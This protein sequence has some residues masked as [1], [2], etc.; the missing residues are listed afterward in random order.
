MAQKKKGK[1]NKK[2]KKGGLSV[3]LVIFIIIPLLFIGVLDGLV[4]TITGI[5]TTVANIVLEVLDI[6][7][8][9][10]RQI[11]LTW[12]TYQW[13]GA[14][15]DNFCSRLFGSSHFN[16][17]EYIFQ[18]QSPEI[19]ITEEQ[20]NQEM[21]K[22]ESVIDLEDAGLTR[23][24]VADMLLAYLSNMYPENYTIKIKLGGLT[25]PKKANGKISLLKVIENEDGTQEFVD[26]ACYSEEG[27]T[28]IYQN[29]YLANLNEDGSESEYSKAV[30]KFLGQCY[31]IG[32]TAGTIKVYNFK[33]EEF[34]EHLQ[35]GDQI[36]D[37]NYIHTINSNATLQPLDYSTD[38]N[39]YATPVEL[40]TSLMLISGSDGFLDAFID[41]V[42]D[43]NK[44]KVGIY[45]TSIES[46]ETVIE[47][48]NQTTVVS[49]T[50]TAQNGYHVR[51]VTDEG[52]VEDENITCEV[53]LGAEAEDI[54]YIEN[55]P[56]KIGL[57]ITNN[58]D[59]RVT[60]NLYLNGRI[61]YDPDAIMPNEP[62]QISIRA[63][64]Y[65]FIWVDPPTTGATREITKQE[66]QIV[67]KTKTINIVEEKFDT[68]IISVESWHTIIET[69][70]TIKKTNTY[71]SKNENAEIVEMLSD[72]Y[73]INVVTQ[74]QNNTYTKAQTPE[75]FAIAEI[76]NDNT[77]I[78][79][80]SS[81]SNRDN[82]LLNCIFNRV[83]RTGDENYQEYEFEQMDVSYG[84]NNTKTLISNTTSTLETTVKNEIDNTDVFLGL[85]SNET[86]EYTLGVQ[87]KSK[88]AGGK[89]VKYKD[90]YNEQA[91]VGE[92]L[93]NG[94]DLLFELLDSYSS[95]EGITQVMKYIMWRYSGIDYGVTTFEFDI[96]DDI[97]FSSV[98]QV[99]LGD[100][101]E[102]RI[103]YSLRFSGFN[104]EAISAI[105]AT[106]DYVSNGN[107]NVNRNQNEAIGIMAWSGVRKEKLIE[108][109]NSQGKPWQDE[110]IQIQYLIAEL[111]Q[112]PTGEVKDY[113]T[114]QII[115]RN[116]YDYNSLCNATTV[117]DATKA[118]L[119]TFNTEGI[120]QNTE[121]PQAQI[122]ES[123]K[124]Y[125]E[126][127]EGK[128]MQGG[129]FRYE[130]VQLRGE[131]TPPPVKRKGTFTSS[132]TGRTFTVYYQGAKSDKYFPG[133]CNRAS[134][135]SI[136][137]GYKKANQTEADVACDAL[138]AGSNLLS[139]PNSTRNFLSKYNLEMRINKYSYSQENIRTLLM[140]GQYIAVW[141]KAYGTPVYGASGHKYT[142]LYH[143]VAILG[144]RNNNGTEE[145][146]ISNSTGG[147]KGCGWKNINEFEV[148]KNNIVY[149]NNIY[150]KQ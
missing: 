75:I 22:L 99:V 126:E 86:G 91:E 83:I 65:Q 132:I 25:I 29:E 42:N 4:S 97:N 136:A 72:S 32:D 67:K 78:S 18:M 50:S 93:E 77:I 137:S 26:M 114:F 116:G 40:M 109:A 71:Y 121:L 36:L 45:D 44:I 11:Q 1:Q 61:V 10:F 145:I 106:M 131:N 66:T 27:L 133:K 7:H 13:T 24:S 54:E 2:S 15:I 41:T 53:V 19:E 79:R 20:F 89:I 87:F 118:F 14:Q 73:V 105:M 141:L 111:T 112:N 3:V 60:V 62:I 39:K 68:A 138:S 146:F 124:E 51:R 5:A 115:S 52:D 82:A 31:T 59:Q 84:I 58:T 110:D 55:G 129:E 107:I 81:S 38:V 8:N 103:W 76:F 125:K 113:A 142:S 102:E 104:D 34:T 12:Q 17:R 149:F 6:T 122:I 100:T 64:N 101:L 90:V 80:L 43:V 95:T 130:L 70:N 135:A 74:M 139:D 47:E 134:A 37:V 85:L 92:L 150:E 127:Y 148:C 88:S 28:N 128:I 120:G 123:A 140:N 57:K 117:E 96:F 98:G 108:Y 119:A 9:P 30:R 21:E 23:K 144:Y 48:Y 16:P 94:A 63:H 49:G 33:T 35:Y 143:W 46:T 56:D 69:E 147:E